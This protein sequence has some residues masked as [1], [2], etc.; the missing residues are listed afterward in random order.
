MTMKR[1]S[2]LLIIM[3]LS[4]SVS[5]QNG[6]SD[7]LSAGVSDANRFADSYLSPGSEALSYGLANG[8]YDTASSLDEWRFTVR[9][10]GNLTFA[11]DEDKAFIL[12]PDQYENLEFANGD[13]RAPREVAT[14]FG[15]NDPAVRVR[16]PS[17]NPLFPDAEFDLPNGLGESGVDF[18]PTVFVQAGLGLPGSLEVKARFVP[19]TTVDEV[20]SQLYGGAVQWSV[21]D[22]FRD[23]DRQIQNDDDLQLGLIAGYTRLDA[24]YDFEDGLVVNG[25]NQRI[26]TEASTWLFSSIIS[27]QF[28]I[29]NV[30]GGLGY[31]T[32]DVQSD[33][34]GTY[35]VNAGIIPVNSTTI[36]DPITVT[37]DVSGLRGNAGLGIVAGFFRFNVDYAIQEYNNLSFSIGARF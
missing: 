10:V 14:V 32:G 28:G 36:E 11:S 4:V 16:I 34:L 7:L 23:S 19:E 22:A 20:T 15:E 12:D 9:V 33:L 27:K 18:L 37:T 3:S 26:E 35:S 25:D 31:V 5:A 24:T 1:I 17:N 2:A 6:F 8:W 30:Y 29:L 21:L 13:A